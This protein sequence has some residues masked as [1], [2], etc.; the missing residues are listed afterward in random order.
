MHLETRRE[1]LGRCEV[2]RRLATS[3]VALLLLAIVFASPAVAA[4]PAASGQINVSVVPRSKVVCT[5]V[6][7]DHIDLRSNAPWRLTLL[8]P[9]GTSTVFGDTTRGE[10]L[11][12]EL[13]EGTKAWWVES[14][15]ARE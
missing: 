6:D 3:V 5:V 4:A 8:T 7:Q 14:D 9:A 10:T 13:P 1:S 15:T 11:R 2:K 12:V